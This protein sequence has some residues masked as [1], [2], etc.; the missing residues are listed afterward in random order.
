[1]GQGGEREGHRGRRGG[2]QRERRGGKGE[3]GTSCSVF[4][5]VVIGVFIGTGITR[6]IVVVGNFFWFSCLTTF[7]VILYYLFP[8]H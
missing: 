7:E 1:M 5:I 2:V 6:V 8:L 4:I 3:R